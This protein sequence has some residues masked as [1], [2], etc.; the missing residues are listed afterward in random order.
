MIV[1]NAEFKLTDQP[2]LAGI[3]SGTLFW[4]G[5]RYLTHILPITFSTSPISSIAF[6]LMYSLC[7]YFYA[8]TMIFEPGY[9]PKAGGISQQKSVVDDLLKNWKFDDQNFC[10]ACMIRMPLRSKHCKRCNRCVAKHD[11]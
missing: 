7:A 4:V 6:A 1:D 9:V 8:C 11:Q 10:V 2:W 3:F 5:V